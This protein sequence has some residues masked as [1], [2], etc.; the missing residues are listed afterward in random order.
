MVL[1]ALGR[2][3]SIRELRDNADPGRDGLSL[4]TLRDLLGTFG[5]RTSGLRVAGEGFREIPLPAIVK[6]DEAHYVVL[7]RVANNRLT[8]V[9]PAHGRAVVGVAEFREHFQGVALVPVDASGMA[10]RRTPR[11]DALAFVRPHLTGVTPRVAILLALGLVLAGVGMVPAV[12]TQVVVDHVVPTGSTASF[13][14]L[15]TVAAGLLGALVLMSL[16][17][18]EV[19]IWFE[20][21]LDA[22]LM[23]MVLGRLL[24]LPYRYFQTRSAGD[25]L[26][27]FS[28]TA[29]IRDVLSG[30]LVATLVDVVFVAGYLVMVGLR[31][32]AYV[33]AIAVFALLQ[34]VAIVA[35]ARA[36][37]RRAEQEMVENAVA[38]GVLLETV[39]SVEVVK[40]L[41]I[42]RESFRRWRSAF[43]RQLAAGVARSRIDNHLLA[44]LDGLMFIAPI[45]FLL[46]GAWTVVR[47]EMTLGTMVALNALAISALAPVRSI[48][49]NLQVLQTVRVHLARL[50]DILD[51]S[52]EDV[53]GGLPGRALVG[54]IELDSVGFAYGTGSP[55]VIQDVTC[56]VAPGEL[57]AVVGPSGS[58][59]STLSR[60][61][62][63]LL[64][65]TSGEVRFDGVP[66]TSLNLASLRQQCGVV[67]Q[68]A[69][70]FS[71]SIGS[72][73]RAGRDDVDDQ[74][75]MLALDAAC[76]ADD[77]R[78]MPLGLH[79][80]LGDEGVGLSG[81][82]K[83][84]LAIARALA[85]RPRVLVLDEATS[86][87]DGPTELRVTANL[88]A[89]AV[90][91]VVIAHR[92]S[93]VRRAD[94]ILFLE[95]GRLQ[96]VGT[97][98]ELMADARYAAFVS[99]QLMDEV[100][101]P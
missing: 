31:S 11:T 21:R 23:G 84:R 97:H 35:T 92:L 79:T 18:G 96:A 75:V 67:T 10:R 57:V 44:V 77:V 34:V 4:R 85:R 9:D 100:P 26:V 38:Q 6:W 29:F 12:L 32:W 54:G 55:A 36:A 62:L 28:S 46:V 72:N 37:R 64:M 20:R 7:E 91:R 82:Q 42:E 68:D 48:G 63:G 56:A 98:D 81:G 50:R 47:S 51:E 66:V 90:T 41:G 94:K 59:K 76:L 22:S 16:W 40:A 101:V 87:L 2:H 52:P 86:H 80:P 17:R 65:P 39:R 25:L 49:L 78:R 74:A 24:S 88:Q 61:M 45:V 19:A 33:G 60:L 93:T 14:G 83:Q 13:D 27:R 5:L 95:G 30:R 71:G 89:L 53:R 3:T 43:D 1:S 58:G 99:S 69:E 73:V 70:I 15:V 8:I